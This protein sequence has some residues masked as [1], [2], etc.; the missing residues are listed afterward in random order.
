MKNVIGRRP[1]AAGP[2]RSGG[3]AH[4]Q[5]KRVDTLQAKAELALKRGDRDLALQLLKEK[6]SYLVRVRR[7]D[8]QGNESFQVVVLDLKG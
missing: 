3:S 6:A 5:Q 8:L 4:D 7:V 2:R 1:L